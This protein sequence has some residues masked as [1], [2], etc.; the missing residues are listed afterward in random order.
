LDKPTATQARET[1][2]QLG[3]AGVRV[4]APVDSSRWDIVS[5]DSRERQHGHR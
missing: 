2:A 5:G 4:A 1:D 3:D